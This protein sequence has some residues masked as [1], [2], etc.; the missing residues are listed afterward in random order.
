MAIGKVTT[1][2]TT[3]ASIVV[4]GANCNTVVIQNNSAVDIRISIDGGASFT[5]PYNQTK[6]GTN[7]TVN[8]GILLKASGGTYTLSNISQIGYNRPIIAIATSGTAN[9]IDIVTD[10]YN[11]TFPT[12]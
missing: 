5:Y 2:T 1:L 11:S 10:G 3:A 4:P 9:L 12:A 7:P 8:N 6:T